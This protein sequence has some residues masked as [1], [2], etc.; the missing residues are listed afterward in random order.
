V[1]EVLNTLQKPVNQRS[2][3]LVLEARNG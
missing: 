3:M 2:D 1:C